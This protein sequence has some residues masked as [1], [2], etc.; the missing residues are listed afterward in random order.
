[1]RHEHAKVIE[2]LL[3]WE[4][5]ILIFNILKHCRTPNC[6]EEISR[7]QRGPDTLSKLE[8]LVREGTAGLVILVVVPECF[9]GKKSNF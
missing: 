8:W 4:V 6:T 1:V 9:Y 5:L 3:L 7:L 2:E